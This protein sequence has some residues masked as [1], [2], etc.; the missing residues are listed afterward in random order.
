MLWQF[1][2][3]I[4]S[5]CVL[6]L[7][8]KIL[9]LKL[10]MALLAA[11]LLL[12]ILT[13][14]ETS[15]IFMAMISV[16]TSHNSA[17]TMICV[18]L[19]GILGSLLKKYGFLDHIV[20]ALKNLI[21]SKKLLMCCIPAAIGVLTVPGGAYL[22][23]PFVDE[24]GKDIGA[25]P[26]SRASINLSFRHISMFVYPFS[27][28]MLY[29]SAT[30]PEISLYSLIGLNAGFIILMQ[31]A[32]FILYMPRSQAVRYAP[33]TLKADESSTWGNVRELLIYS[34]PI[35]TVV[36]AAS[37]FKLPAAV[38]LTLS[39]L[40]SIGL[41]SRKDLTKTLRGG[42]VLEPI[43][44]M[45]G[46]FFL[47]NTIKNLEQINVLFLHIFTNSSGIV[48]LLAMMAGSFVLGLI[49]GIS[50]APL[51]VFL[52]MLVSLQLSS[53]QL[54]VYCFFLWTWSFLG[55][56]FSPLHLCQIVTVQYMKVSV[57]ELYR[58]HLRLF[59]WVLLA[60][61]TLFGV[62]WQLLM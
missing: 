28:S 43:L 53:T 38:A 8:T 22:S 31:V 34:S 13:F 24:L 14:M 15:R 44:M 9:R 23:A 57:G 48:V 4:F 51:G 6:P 26:V 11:A 30:V 29:F 25:P 60:S 42:V 55:Y 52:P 16:V 18:F 2:A 46:V 62:Y 12:N 32:S 56:Y 54:L 37:I 27:T 17:H 19:M 50:L 41:S 47:Q 35:Y 33:E 5:F 39:C 59:P 10:W 3:V 7:L 61:F 1:L 40:M 45:A 49:T 36:L 20:H 21:H 58:S